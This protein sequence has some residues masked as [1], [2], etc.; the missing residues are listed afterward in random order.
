MAGEDAGDDDY[1]D[2][3]ELDVTERNEQQN[4]SGNGLQRKGKCRCL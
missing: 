2:E 4:N 1:D 3:E